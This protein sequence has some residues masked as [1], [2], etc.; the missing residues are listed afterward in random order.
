MEFSPS[1]YHDWLF[2]GGPQ[3][4]PRL[5]LQDRRRFQ[6]RWYRQGAPLDEALAVVPEPARLALKEGR[7]FDWLALH[8]RVDSQKDGASR[9]LFRAEDGSLLE[10]VILR[11]DSGRTTLCV[12]SQVGCA[13]GCQFCATGQL[14][15]KRDLSRDEIVDQLLLTNRI[16]AGEG[17]QVRNVVFMGMGE[18]LLNREALFEALELLVHPLGFGLAARRVNVSTVGLPGPMVELARKFPQVS[19]AL[20]L[21]GARPELREA[22][23]P[24]ARRIGLDEL[25]EAVAEV[26]A[27]SGRTLMVEYLLLGGVND[28]DEDIEALARWVDGLDVSVNL[29]TYNPVPSLPFVPSLRRDEFAGHL[30]AK[31]L[32]VTRRYSLGSDIAAACGQLASE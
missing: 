17:R 9:L 1:S 25:H 20:S 10:A 15:L 23:I 4:K 7:R 6:A 13:M 5:A 8:S 11:I 12:S 16:L 19:L 2:G 18:P 30:R 3:L 14:G 26:N 21:H 28:G 29:I 31:G 22:L 32:V 24:P 27:L